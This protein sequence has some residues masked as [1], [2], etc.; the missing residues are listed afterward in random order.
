MMNIIKSLN[1]FEVKPNEVI[2]VECN[3]EAPVDEM[4]ELHEFIHKMFPDNDVVT[5]FD[6]VNISSAPKEEVIKCLEET[7]AYLKGQI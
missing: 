2:V 4:A 3:A 1:K 5:V 6:Y 7:I